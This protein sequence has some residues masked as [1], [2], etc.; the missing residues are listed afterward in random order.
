MAYY[1][2]IYDHWALVSRASLRPGHDYFTDLLAKLD[3]I[4]VPRGETSQAAFDRAKL[5]TH[6][7]TSW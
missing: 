4:T 2:V 5:K 3:S 6:A 1:K 7:R